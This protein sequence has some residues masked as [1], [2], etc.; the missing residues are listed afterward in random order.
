[1]RLRL[2]YTDKREGLVPGAFDLRNRRPVLGSSVYGALVSV[3]WRNSAW[4]EPITQQL[5]SVIFVTGLRPVRGN[6]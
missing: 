3:T 4:V 2:I 5:Q 1:M 6:L